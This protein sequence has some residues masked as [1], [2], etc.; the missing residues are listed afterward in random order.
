M[1]N[2]KKVNFKYA[3]KMKDNPVTIK[4]FCNF[5]NKIHISYKRYLLNDFAK[6]FKIL[7]QNINI[8]FDKSKNPFK[9]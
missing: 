3:V 7:N 4:I 6:K 1:I 2:G 5:S 9:N 8:I